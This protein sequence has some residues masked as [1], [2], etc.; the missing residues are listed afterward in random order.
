MKK[1]QIDLTI[2]L[3]ESPEALWEYF[4]KTGSVAA[5]LRYSQKLEKTEELVPADLTS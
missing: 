2:T 1:N 3:C 4:E 5:Y